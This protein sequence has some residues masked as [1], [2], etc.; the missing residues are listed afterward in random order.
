METNKTNVKKV[1]LNRSQ[2]QSLLAKI[3]TFQDDCDNTVRGNIFVGGAE[4]NGKVAGSFSVEKEGGYQHNSAFLVPKENLIN[5]NPSEP[6]SFSISFKK[7]I[8]TLEGLLVF[9][10]DI[11]IIDKD[12]ND[13]N[14]YMGVSKAS[15]A[16]LIIEK[17][18]FSSIS[19]K[20]D[21]EK[22][23]AQI[24]L[25]ADALFNLI[26]KG[27]FL[28]DKSEEGVLSSAAFLISGNKVRAMSSVNGFSLIFNAETEA[29]IKYNDEKIKQ[30]KEKYPNSAISKYDGIA[31]SI[32]SEAINLISKLFT[33]NG[34]AARIEGKPANIAIFIAENKATIAS[35][36]GCVVNVP[37][38]SSILPCINAPSQLR[39]GKLPNSKLLLD[40]VK[41]SQSIQFLDKTFDV[42]DALSNASKDATKLKIKKVDDKLFLGLS[43]G[44]SSTRIDLQPNS[45]GEDGELILS[46]DKVK[47]ALST[48]G[49]ANIVLEMAYLNEN[50]SGINSYAFFYDAQNE[51]DDFKTY[52]FLL[53]CRPDAVPTVQS[54]DD[55]VKET[56]VIVQ[57]ND[58]EQAT[59]EKEA[60][61][62]NIDNVTIGQD[63]GDVVEGQ[64]DTIQGDETITND[65][66]T[67]QE[68]S[69]SNME[70][71]YTDNVC[72][73]NFP[74]DAANVSEID[75]NDF[76]EEM[77]ASE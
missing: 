44:A 71:V 27:A 10:E 45:E 16:N 67:V 41:F 53:P 52:A 34:P 35:G 65:T 29:V 58:N 39:E 7:F 38:G 56:E 76:E 62:P 47:K 32:P 13:P 59:E 30:Y 48:L 3:S 26:K 28:A 24:S 8:K 57:S 20:P 37:L 15:I 50:E 63:N 68:N 22:T 72:E 4:K 66:E 75:A 33:C 6:F 43:S 61:T 70:N 40:G 12:P 54:V 9:G 19:V 36:V 42:S 14:L 73:Y 31:V 74:D 60:S 51:N 1:I 69:N 49:K 25:P 46:M 23:M 77:K 55:T 11:E 5:I 2:A 17:F 18:P 64:T 21:P